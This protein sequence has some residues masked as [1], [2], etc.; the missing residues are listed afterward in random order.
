MGS[1]ALSLYHPV[2]LGRSPAPAP[3]RVPPRRPCSIPIRA[4]FLLVSCVP[5]P[6]CVPLDLSVCACV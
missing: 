2:P 1:G 4:F 3:S 5:C 6:E